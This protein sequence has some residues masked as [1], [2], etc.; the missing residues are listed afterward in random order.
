MGQALK[1]SAEQTHK[2]MDGAVDWR[3]RMSDHIAFALLIYT[4]L[5]IFV[6][7]IALTANHNSILP[8]FALV[9]LVVAIIP[10]CWMMEKRWSDLSEEDAHNPEL[11]AI[12]ARDRTLV[13]VAAIGLPLGITA[14]IK[15]MALLFG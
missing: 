5:Q 11:A 3:R 14:F 12:F 8:Y 1:G 10:A 7:S 2:R 4:G 13:W 15:G 9:V 6:T